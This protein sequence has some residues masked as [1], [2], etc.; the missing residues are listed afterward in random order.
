M[1]NSALHIAKN[2]VFHFRTK[3]ISI[4]YH[5]VRKVVEEGSVNMQKIHTGENLV[6][7]MIKSININ[8]FTW[9]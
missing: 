5:F 3:H 8:N 4:H 6:D 7:V 1:T 2:L 9:V